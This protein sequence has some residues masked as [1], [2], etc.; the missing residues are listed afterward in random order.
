MRKSSYWLERPAAILFSYSSYSCT[1]SFLRGNLLE[2]DEA[3]QVIVAQ[4]LLPGYPDQP[5]LYSWL[6]YFFQTIWF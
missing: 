1:S 6:Q 5:P 2:L 3:E 4:Q